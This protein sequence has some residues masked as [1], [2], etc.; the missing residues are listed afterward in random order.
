MRKSGKHTPLLEMNK[1]VG[2]VGDERKIR[3]YCNDK[4]SGF[5]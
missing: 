3:K 5:N 4:S 2:V 1:A